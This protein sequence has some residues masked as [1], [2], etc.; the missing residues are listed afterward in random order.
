MDLGFSSAGVNYKLGILHAMNRKLLK[1]GLFREIKFLLCLSHSIT[2][3]RTWS[4]TNW[5]PWM[6]M[7]TWRPLRALTK[8]LRLSIWTLYLFD[9]MSFRQENFDDEKSSP[10][11]LLL[12]C[13]SFRNIVTK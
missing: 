9:N 7:S 1:V 2:S 6:A 4:K 5:L 12:V 3:S 11:M 10:Y 8:T 13:A